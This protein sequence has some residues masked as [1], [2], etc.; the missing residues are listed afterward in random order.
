MRGSISLGQACIRTV[1]CPD[2]TLFVCVSIFAADKIGT[3]IMHACFKWGRE[4]L[5]VFCKE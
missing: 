3:E 2:V 1:H 4:H 5:F